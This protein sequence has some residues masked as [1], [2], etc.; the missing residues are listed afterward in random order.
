MRICPDCQ[1][2]LDDHAAFCDN[3]GLRLSDVAEAPKPAA[4]V[5]SPA[6]AAV[7]QETPR[8]AAPGMCSSC[9]YVNVPGEMFCQNCGVQ[10]APVAST[11][12]PPPTPVDA[13]VAVAEPQEAPQVS[14]AAGAADRAQC[15]SCGFVNA[16]GEVFCQN[17]G[18]Q[19]EAD[20]AAAQAASQPATP[21]TP[22]WAPSAETWPRMESPIPS[23]VV[24]P[25]IGKLIVQAAG[26]E[27]KLPVGQ[28]EVT[29][30]R[31]DPVRDV[32]PDIDLTSFGGDTAG[33]SRMHARLLIQGSQVFL[34]DL[35]STNYTFLNR[36]RLQPGQRYPLTHGDEIR[37][38]LLVLEYLPE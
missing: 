27:I 31:S 32:F 14:E 9:G 2:Q 24:Q 28:S 4:E 20:E 8:E 3:C 17:C 18:F 22:A 23:E 35:N 37:L 33:V 1:T 12:P 11:P 16:P 7:A 13:P 6:V 21:S 19:L 25:A 5:S 10:L 15:T 38:G 29:I 36:Q 30:G 34:E 26:A